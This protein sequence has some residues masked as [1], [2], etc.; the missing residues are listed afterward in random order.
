MR[1]LCIMHKSSSM[2]ALTFYVLGYLLHLSK[3]PFIYF[4]IILSNILLSFILHTS[5][6]LSIKHS[7]GKKENISQQEERKCC[8]L[9]QY[10]TRARAKKVKWQR[11]VERGV[12]FKCS[13]VTNKSQ[14][15]PPRERE[16]CCCACQQRYNKL[17]C[18]TEK[19]PSQIALSHL[20]F[21]FPF[22]SLGA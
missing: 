22:Q 2:I 20:F 11:D 5:K 18:L 6:T 3:L 9:I 15:M 10:E 21:S 16:V 4:I 14:N 1:F 8:Q 19:E 12:A 13:M 7:S 17:H